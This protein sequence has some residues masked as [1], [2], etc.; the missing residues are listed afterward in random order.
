MYS[1]SS[2]CRPSD[3]EELFNLR[4]A[5]ARNVVERGFGVFKRRFHVTTNAPEYSLK[6][7]AQL[8]PCLCVV[9]NFILMHEP[10]DTS[11]EVWRQDNSNS[12]DMQPGAQRD[13]MGEGEE[14]YNEDSMNRLEYITDEER[15][16]ASEF[17][18]N[19]AEEMWNDY[20]AELR[21]RG[22]SCM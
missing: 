21:R 15:L 11:I 16:R 2:N 17:R 14:D 20:Q 22:I 4:H 6:F 13:T 3:R 5:Q 1:H 9:H 12:G 18:D 10:E 8:I 19:M 7:Q